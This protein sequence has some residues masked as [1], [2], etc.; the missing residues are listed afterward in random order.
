MGTPAYAGFLPRF[1]GR[2]RGIFRNRREEIA[3][4]LAFK[5]REEG[6][7]ADDE[8]VIEAVQGIGNG[9]II[10]WLI[11]HGDD[12]LALVLKLLPLFLGPKPG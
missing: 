1:R 6:Y 12:I 4:A 10:K 9:A 11:E 7:E 3:A 8:E 5:L 2:F